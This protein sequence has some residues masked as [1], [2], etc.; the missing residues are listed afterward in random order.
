MGVLSALSRW[1]RPRQKELLCPQ[2]GDL[3]GVARLRSIPS[4]LTLYRLSGAQLNPTSAQ[5]Q[6]RS[7]PALTRC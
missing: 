6:C 5:L 3:L 7:D 2:C 1:L 4:N